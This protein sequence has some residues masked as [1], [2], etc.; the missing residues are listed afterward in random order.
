MPGTCPSSTTMTEPDELLPNPHPGEIL[1][2]EFLRPMNL[3]QNA[4]AR[5][6]RRLADMPGPQYYTTPYRSE[7]SGVFAW[8]KSRA[9]VSS[10]RALKELAVALEEQS[11][12]PP[13]DLTIKDK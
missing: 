1:L 12:Q 6:I 2:E 11:R 13:I 9:T 5:A 8:R 7:R 10:A 3:G 4:L